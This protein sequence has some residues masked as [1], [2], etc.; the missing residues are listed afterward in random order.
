M[1]PL[2]A[3]TDALRQSDIRAVTFEVNR[4]G[5][6]NLGQGI[7]DLAT[8][9]EIVEATVEALRH[10]PQIYTAYNGTP[11]LRAAIAEKARSFNA[12]PLDGPASVVV[13][14]GSTGAFVAAVLTLCEP[15]DE[16]VLF[17]P[18]YG[19]H[20]GILRLHGV[21][22]VA[23]PLAK[24]EGRWAFDADRLAA[25]ISP[26]TKAVVVCTPANPSG[27][28]WAEDELGPLYEIAE[29]HDLWV[30]T[31]EIYEHMVYDG[32]RH[33]S[34]ASLDGAFERTVT[35]SG[36]SKTFNMTGWRLGYA[37]APT[38]V[39]DK[40]GL[41]NDLV[42][43]CAPAPL[44]HGLAAALPMPDAYYAEMLADYAAKRTRMVDALRACGFDADPPEGAYYVLAGLGDRLGTP[45]F[46]D[47]RA[48]TTTLIETA[49]VACVPG[50]SF[51]ADP[52]D[53]DGH[54]RFCYA[55]E[56]PVLDEACDR[57]VAA[58]G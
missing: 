10:G 28:V 19:Y 12:I 41:V 54:L 42:A 50:P 22:P 55:K 32:R 7:C 38:V 5:G 40:L 20:A 44:Q 9:P 25:A 8:P 58:F 26:Q 52:A 17:E 47:A 35:L 21:R 49:G 45:G 34:P 39:A 18:F 15:G 46:E 1:K 27:K 31:D 37:I 6:I 24:A 56:R 3:R 57:L 2:A 51:F 43:I 13:T 30:V 23:V 48:A 53:G 4:V 36:V 29:R 11:D 14:S 16:V 33:V